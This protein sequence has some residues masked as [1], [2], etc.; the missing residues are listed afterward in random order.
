MT[1]TTE[2]LITDIFRLE[3]EAKDLTAQAQELRD[4]LRQ[5]LTEGDNF[6]TEN[7]IQ[8]IASPNRR[9][10]SKKALTLVRER[11]KD[12]PGLADVLTEAVDG[13]KLK[14]LYPEVYVEAQDEGALRVTIK[15]AE[16][17]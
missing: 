17:D 7:G 11:S 14:A 13:P 15:E 6:V 4:E 9:F 8:V 16:E 5:V 2:D 10:N 12:L 1:Y 3:Q